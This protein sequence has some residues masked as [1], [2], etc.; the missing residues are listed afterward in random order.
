MTEEI[1][2]GKMTFTQCSGRTGKTILLSP[3]K[4]IEPYDVY[5]GGDLIR[6][7]TRVALI[8]AEKLK[9]QIIDELLNER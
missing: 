4:H 5:F 9:K 3:D 7:I 1:K 8:E 2:D 6:R